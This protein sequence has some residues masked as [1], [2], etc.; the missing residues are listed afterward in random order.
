MKADGEERNLM[1]IFVT[2]QMTRTR[3]YSMG[4]KGR[5]IPPQ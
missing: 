5:F 1:S 3:Y 2:K 4:A